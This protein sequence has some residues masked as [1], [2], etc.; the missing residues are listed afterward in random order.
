MQ[1]IFPE[2]QDF[3]K[4]STNIFPNGIFPGLQNF[5][6]FRESHLGYSIQKAARLTTLKRIHPTFYNLSYKKYTMVYADI[7]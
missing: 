6:T 4:N 2:L 1:K 5:L 3:F 7:K